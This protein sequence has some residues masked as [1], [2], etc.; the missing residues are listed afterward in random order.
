MLSILSEWAT[1]PLQPAQ[2]QKSCGL[3][4]LKRL[5]T[6]RSEDEKKSSSPYDYFLNVWPFASYFLPVALRSPLP[7]GF[8]WQYP[9]A[10]PSF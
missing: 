4:G 1:M 8:M 2:P 3:P 6:D 5:S 9:Q 10:L 7:A